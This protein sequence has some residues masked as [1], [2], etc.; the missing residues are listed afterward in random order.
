M[1]M[2]DNYRDEFDHLAKCTKDQEHLIWLTAISSINMT[3]GLIIYFH[4][5]SGEVAPTQTKLTAGRVQFK[6]FCKLNS[7]DK[8]TFYEL[9][10]FG[11][12]YV[13]KEWKKM[14]L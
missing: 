4:M 3:H 5:H 14:I 1:Y 6:K 8:R 13:F 2:A 7:F 10:C 11:L 9:N 12:R